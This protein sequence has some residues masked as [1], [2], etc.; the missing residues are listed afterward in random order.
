MFLFYQGKLE[1]HLK[2]IG[3]TMIRYL[4]H[5]NDRVKISGNDSIGSTSFTNTTGCVKNIDRYFSWV[6][7]KDVIDGRALPVLNYSFRT[8]DI[9]LISRKKTATHEPV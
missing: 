6:V 3:K 4:F 2:K 5:V 8:K 1:P 7:L 9:V